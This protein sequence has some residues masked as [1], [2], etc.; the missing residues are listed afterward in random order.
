MQEHTY[1]Q[2]M[3][4]TKLPD[5]SEKSVNVTE[6]FQ[7][8]SILSTAPTE[9]SNRVMGR[10][11]IIRKTISSENGV[12]LK[13][14]KGETMAMGVLGLSNNPKKDFFEGKESISE[15]K[16]PDGSTMTTTAQEKFHADG[17]VYS[18]IVNELLSA[19]K[20]QRHVHMVEQEKNGS[21]TITEMSENRKFKGNDYVGQREVQVTR[22]DPER[23]AVQAVSFNEKFKGSNSLVKDGT[24][25]RN[26]EIVRSEAR[27]A[28][29]EIDNVDLAMV[30]RIQGNAQ[31]ITAEAQS[32]SM[33][34]PEVAQVSKVASPAQPVRAQDLER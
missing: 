9:Q 13:E 2:S 19:D 10:E 34:G 14:F 8:A 5:G 23:D 27:V 11:E 7:N 22:I 31:L 15:V 30:H 24:F 20:T 33:A 16:R 29:R 17:R 6:N 28:N 25:E 1:Y 4:K 3:T 12:T 26:P 18:S 21:I 32:H